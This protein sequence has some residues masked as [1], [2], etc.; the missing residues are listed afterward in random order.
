ME[1]VMKNEELI[2]IPEGMT[3]EELEALINKH[4]IGP[5]SERDRRIMWA[6]LTGNYTY[7]QLAEEYEVSV[8][9]VQ[10]ILEKGKGIIYN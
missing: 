1:A 3:A 8:S 7:E 4:I 10:R 9:T 6:Y 2:R 5:R